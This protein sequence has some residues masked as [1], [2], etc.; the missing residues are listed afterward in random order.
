MAS[1]ATAHAQDLVILN[2]GK[3]L[4]LVGHD[5]PSKA[6]GLI[7]FGKDPALAGAPDPSCPA[8]SSVELGL[9][10]VAANAVVRGEKV[11]LDC[12]RW[13]RTKSGWRYDDPAAPGGVES[14]TYGPTG[15][16]V[17]LAGSAT[18]PAP[19]PVGYAFAWFQ[20]GTRRFH[21]RFHVFRKNRADLI[22]SRKT[23]TLAAEGE[24]AFWGIMWGDDASEATAQ[25]TLATLNRAAKRSKADARSRFLLAMLRLYRFGQLTERIASPSEAA[26]AELRAAVAAFDQAEPL[27]WDR[28][29]RAG[30]SRV[31]GFAA[32][33]R[34]SLAVATAD[35]ALHQQALVD[36]DYAISINAFFNVFDLMAVTQAEPP[37]S[38]AF[39]QAFGAVS[40]YISDPS[41]LE[42]AVT[43]PEVCTGNGLA[44]TALPGTFVVF[45]DLYAKAGD[46]AGATSWYQFAVATERGW[47]FE[48]LGAERLATVDARVA[49]YQDADPGND[50]P[51]IGAGKQAC[52]SCH[53]RLVDTD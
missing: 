41:T 25:R 13:R 39:Q 32:A 53:N 50:P 12:A 35:E 34:Y 45:G 48:G 51:I 20:V 15:L 40:A 8:S 37:S 23:S 26:L 28:T 42:C 49:A 10:T 9:F 11:T 29:A 18:L 30:D 33:A 16:T 7:R 24:S 17:R 43:Q 14:I 27:L 19:G 5:D 21:G 38:A 2:H 22:A 1:V 47:P 46:V 44:P 6:H 52:A 36:L 31:P 4:R 3:V